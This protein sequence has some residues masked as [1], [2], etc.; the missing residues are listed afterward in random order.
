M[1]SD[2]RTPETFTMNPAK[3]EEKITDRTKAIL[4]VHIY[5]LPADM[6]GINQIAKKHDLAVIEDKLGVVA[7]HLDYKFHRKDVD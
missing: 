6:D 7:K 4:P 2:T 3:I 1:V 5:G